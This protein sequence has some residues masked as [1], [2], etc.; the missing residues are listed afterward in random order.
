ME[1]TC[2]ECRNKIKCELERSS[3][4]PGWPNGNLTQ[5]ECLVNKTLIE[6]V[7]DFVYE[8]ISRKRNNN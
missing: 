1:W 7:D 6:S 5:I 2:L 8:P 4:K 3:G